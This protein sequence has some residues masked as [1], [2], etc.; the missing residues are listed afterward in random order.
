MRAAIM[1]ADA[2]RLNPKTDPLDAID[3]V[4]PMR[5]PVTDEVVASVASLAF[6]RAR[7]FTVGDIR[8]IIEA[9]DAARFRPKRALDAAWESLGGGSGRT[10]GK[11]D[12]KAAIDAYNREKGP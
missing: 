9:A 3:R 1:A 6:A 2:A 8:K 5:Q 10:I 7:G 4:H 11:N 12:L